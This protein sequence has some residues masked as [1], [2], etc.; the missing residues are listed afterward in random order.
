M[1]REHSINHDLIK[2]FRVGKLIDHVP[3]RANELGKDQ[4]TETNKNAI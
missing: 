3:V 4:E 1:E 2:S